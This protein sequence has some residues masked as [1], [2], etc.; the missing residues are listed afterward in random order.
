MMEKEEDSLPTIFDFSTI[1]VATNHF[2]NR[3]K[4]GEGGFGTVHKV[5]GQIY[6]WLPSYIHT[7]LSSIKFS[8][9]IARA[10]W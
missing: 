3:N 9:I 1:D 10:H 2:S 6:S 5:G 4:L 8:K 7:D